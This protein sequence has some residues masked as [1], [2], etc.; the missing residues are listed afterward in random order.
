MKYLSK[1]NNVVMI[2][3]LHQAFG[4]ELVGATEMGKD[5]LRSI[6]FG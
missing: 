5:L 3:E 6:F 2:E 4:S 1:R